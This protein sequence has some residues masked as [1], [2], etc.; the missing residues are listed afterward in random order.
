VKIVVEILSGARTGQRLAFDAPAVL[1][2]G[3]HPSNDI[4]FDPTQD[5]DASSRHAELRVE[6]GVV[7]LYDVGSANGTRLQG[8]AVTARTVV[9]SGSEIEFGKGGPRCRILVDGGEG[10]T[11][12]PTM[13]QA[14]AGGTT[15]GG[16]KVG[17]R[18]VAM[19]IDQA[20]H[21]ARGTSRRWQLAAAALGLL[22]LASI[23]A[24]ALALR[25][26]KHDED[27]L[28]KRMVALMDQQR[29]AEKPEQA[30]LQK[31]LDEL[32][33]LLARAGGTASAAEIARSN[34]DAIYLVAVR[35]GVGEDGFCTAFAVDDKRLV[36]NAHCVY[37][38]E[39]HRRKGGQIF[40]VQNGHAE[41]RRDIVRL[42]R[43]PGFRP[44]G[45]ISPDVGWLAVEGALPAKVA[46]AP[47]EEYERLATGDTMFTYGFPGRLADVSAPEAT[48]VSGVI[49]RVTTLDGRIGEPAENR[50]IQHSA[51]T[52]GGT[53][54]SPIFNGLGHVVGVNTGGYVEAVPG[55]DG[56][57]AVV[58][59][60]LP[61]YNFGMRVDL[62]MQLLQ[63]DAE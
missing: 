36:T 57:K 10:E 8:R 34:H 18:T 2:F 40:V 28:R 1:R 44:T 20:L 55:G 19:M 49:G 46:L 58:S 3:R 15:A 9:P 11:V 26:R 38:A 47:K 43:I 12:P 5:R 27:E 59:R 31:K 52:S 22:L 62:V 29:G 13:H 50:L 35:E 45:E 14:G 56:N 23:G 48:F 32:A 4:A 25:A 61:G 7:Y 17:A 39:E 41:V 16:K 42:K 51:F 60:T 63:E 24:A 30:A 6:G 54:G 37:L 33:A 53:S 21:R